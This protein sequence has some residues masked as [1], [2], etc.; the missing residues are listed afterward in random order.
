VLV[1]SA[2]LHPQKGAAEAVRALAALR[3]RARHYKL[4]IVGDG[5]E[6]GALR[7]L[8]AK[9]GCA[10]AVAFA[11]GVRREESPALLAAG[12]V[13]VFPAF[14]GREGLP[15]NVLEA[16]SVGLP[17]VCAE[18]LRDIFGPLEQIAYAPPR[19]ACALADAIERLALRAP[20]AGTLLPD[21]YTLERCIDAYESLLRYWVRC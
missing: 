2:R 3:E 20:P 19:D 11:G 12:N 10:E 8:A 18:G 1:F 6:A 5:A 7:S 9:L 16:L 17:C 4:L 14:G 15:L 21:E 13:F